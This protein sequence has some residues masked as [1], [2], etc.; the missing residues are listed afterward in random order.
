MQRVK[1]WKKKEFKLNK[2]WKLILQICIWQTEHLTDTTA[3]LFSLRVFRIPSFPALD[4]SSINNTRWLLFLYVLGLLLLCFCFPVH[5]F[6]Y[7]KFKC[8][9]QYMETWRITPQPS[10][11]DCRIYWL[12][13]FQSGEANKLGNYL[14]VVWLHSKMHVRTIVLNIKKLKLWLSSEGFELV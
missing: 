5:S 6:C 14:N 12:L 2:W 9:W 13:E 1:P 3:E 7:N 8:A 10:W 4:F 11:R